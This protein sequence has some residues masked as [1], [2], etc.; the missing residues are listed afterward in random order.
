MIYL[1]VDK[2]LHDV[3]ISST[4]LAAVHRAPDCM[5]AI[6]ERMSK[7]GKATRQV[8]RR[9]ANSGM[10]WSW[11]CQVYLC[12][13]NED[14]HIFL[15]REHAQNGCDRD[16]ENIVWERHD[17]KY[18][19]AYLERAWPWQKFGEKTRLLPL[20]LVAFRPCFIKSRDHLFTLVIYHH[21]Q[22]T[23]F[24]FA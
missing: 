8:I 12:G 9:E 13:I 19:S 1:H 24:V 18:L 16:N 15:E 10:K 17:L 20:L 5:R 6:P 22:H 11:A 4:E 23:A 3:Y 21:L 7:F 14:I 2:P